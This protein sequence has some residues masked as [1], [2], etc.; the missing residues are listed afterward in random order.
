MG[1]SYNFSQTRLG[2]ALLAKEKGRNLSGPGP[3][4]ACPAA[5]R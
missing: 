2:V 3:F 5:V 4:M 1:D